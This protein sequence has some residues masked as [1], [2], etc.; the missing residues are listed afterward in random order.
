MRPLLQMGFA[1]FANGMTGLNKALSYNLKNGITGT[2]PLFTIDYS[3]VLISRGDLPNADTAAAA[4]GTAGKVNFTWTD[5]SGTGKALA[6]DTAMLVVYCADKNQSVYVLSGA[7]RSA[8][9][10]VVNVPAFSGKKVQTWLSFVAA[11][12]S[13]IAT[14]DF[15]GEVTV[16]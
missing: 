7:A 2:Y 6:T 14:S 13:E 11:D 4:A 1:Q 5:N 3:V 12:G 9:T 8:G 15:T 10:D 16:L